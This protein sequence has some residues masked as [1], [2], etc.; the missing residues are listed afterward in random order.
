MSDQKLTPLQRA[1]LQAQQP[2]REDCIT[3]ANCVEV[4]G[5]YYCETNGKMLIPRFMEIGRCM[6][7]PSRYK[8][9]EA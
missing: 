8:K 2:P 5:N 1:R 7:V 3:C 4:L 6:G 9:K